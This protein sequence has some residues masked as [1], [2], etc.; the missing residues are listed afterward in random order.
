MRSSASRPWKT[1]GHIVKCLLSVS[2]YSSAFYTPR[3]CTVDLPSAKHGETL[4][5]IEMIPVLKEL[6]SFQVKICEPLIHLVEAIDSN[7]S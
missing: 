6:K 4:V 2:H 7:L 3:A 5:T 1:P